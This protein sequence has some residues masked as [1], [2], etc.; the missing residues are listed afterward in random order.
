M[1]RS[2]SCWHGMFNMWKTIELCSYVNFF[3]CMLCFTK[4]FE[5]TWA[6]KIYFAILLD[7]CRFWWQC[8][9]KC[10]QKS[11]RYRLMQLLLSSSPLLSLSSLP[12]SLHTICMKY[13][14]KWLPPFE[15]RKY[16]SLSKFIL[17]EIG[18]LNSMWTFSVLRVLDFLFLL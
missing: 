13:D 6:I 9:W 1:K 11:K 8:M 16:F 12:S 17:Q 3:V 7:S 10:F 15:I 18:N 14:I 2:L 5:E 4:K